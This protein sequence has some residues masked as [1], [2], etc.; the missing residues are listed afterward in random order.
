MFRLLKKKK[1]MRE[2]KKKTKKMILTIDGR[3]K[4]SC[5]LNHRLEFWWY[6]FHCFVVSFCCKML[7]K[8]FFIRIPHSRNCVLQLSCNFYYNSFVWHIKYEEVWGQWS[9]FE[10]GFL[11]VDQFFISFTHGKRS[12]LNFI[13]FFCLGLKLHSSHVM[14]S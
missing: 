4:K 6:G 14:S 11:K 1:K 8:S 9:I 2:K 10:R 12:F 5:W 13:N 7:L 3:T